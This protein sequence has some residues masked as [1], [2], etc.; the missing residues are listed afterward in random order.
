M[1]MRTHTH[2]FW[3]RFLGLATFFER[4]LSGGAAGVD[5]VE[6]TIGRSFVQR[7]SSR[8]CD[9]GGWVG[10]NGHRRAG[11]SAEVTTGDRRTAAGLDPALKLDAP[12]PDAPRSPA[13]A[14]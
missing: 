2:R 5:F 11:P 1:T 9:G 7:D 4:L 12:D 8:A 6:I 13:G 14:V 10:C 3:Q